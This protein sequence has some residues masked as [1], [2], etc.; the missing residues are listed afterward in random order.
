MYFSQW[1]KVKKLEKARFQS[2]SPKVHVTV[3]Q[4]LKEWD[5]NLLGTVWEQKPKWLPE[6]AQGVHILYTFLQ[7]SVSQAGL[8]HEQQ[9]LDTL[10]FD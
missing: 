1:A 8:S 9:T 4:S 7:H 6:Q 3:I 10:E 5:R 2:P